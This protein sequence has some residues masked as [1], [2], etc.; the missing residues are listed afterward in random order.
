MKLIARFNL[1][2]A[3]HEDRMSEMN[4]ICLFSEYFN[5]KHIMIYIIIYKIKYTNTNLEEYILSIYFCDIYLYLRILMK[6]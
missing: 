6:L 4:I 2:I 5:T 1:E 3:I